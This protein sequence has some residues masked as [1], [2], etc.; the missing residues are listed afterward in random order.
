[1]STDFNGPESDKPLTDQEGQMF[2]AQPI[3]ER[4]RKRKGFGGRKTAS[5]APAAMVSPEPRT[6]AAERDYEE[7]M[8]LDRPLNAPTDAPLAASMDAPLGAATPAREYPRSE[9]AAMNAG[10]TT[11]STLAADEPVG[12]AAPIGGT[13][14]VRSVKSAKSN[15]VAPAAIAA[16]VV[17]LGALGAAGW[18][19]SRDTSGVPE[20]AAGS[21]AT[22]SELAAAPLTPVD[23]P[24]QI[25]A[26]QTPP[27]PVAT[28][29][30]ATPRA[31]V[32]VPRTTARA[33]PATP[34]RS[35]SETGVNASASASTT[36]VLPDGPQPYSSVNPG[37]APTAP[38]QVNPP[39]V[40]LPPSSEAPAAVPA[41]PPTLPQEPPVTEAPKP[42]ATPPN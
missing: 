7:P 11:N 22:E 41:T 19:M 24:A 6:F 34:A 26:N 29:P 12:L 2:A 39:L 36:A 4:N 13:R 33:R 35:A 15:S 42:D 16:A 20:L 10:T 17:G 30:A 27:A 8:A 23:P 32:P 37:T 31:S 25:A 3:W 28:A 40:S 5:V 18:Y 14:N 9:Y 1:M 38:T 21:T